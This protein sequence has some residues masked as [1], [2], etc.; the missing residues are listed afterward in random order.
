MK[1]QSIAETTLKKQIRNLDTQIDIA[2][3]EAERIG[4]R[5]KTL[6]EIRDDLEAEV[7]RLESARQLASASGR[8]K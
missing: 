6:H 5:I 2:N 1:R 3:E 4:A 7:T 8:A